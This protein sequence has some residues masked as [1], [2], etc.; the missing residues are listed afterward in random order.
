MYEKVI[1]ILEE[2]NKELVTQSETYKHMALCTAITIL[3]EKQ[4]QK[5]LHGHWV[6]WE[7]WRGNHDHRIDN[8]VC[9][10]CGFVNHSI[11]YDPKD[12]FD[13]CPKCGIKMIGTNEI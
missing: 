6:I 13:F 1:E 10:D 3:N 2:I 4:N 7:G 9:S 5:D 11:V 12:L 8:A